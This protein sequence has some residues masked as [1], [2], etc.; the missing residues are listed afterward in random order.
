MYA[1][2]TVKSVILSIAASERVISIEEAVSLSRLE[3]EY[4][5]LQNNL[6]Y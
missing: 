1:V 5:V 4:Q 2:D 3:E 6:I